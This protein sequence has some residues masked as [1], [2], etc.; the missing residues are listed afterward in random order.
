MTVVAPCK[1]TLCAKLIVRTT[2]LSFGFLHW[3]KT[4]DSNLLSLILVH[5]WCLSI[6]NARRFDPKLLFCCHLSETV[7]YLSCGKYKRPGGGG[8]G[9]GWTK[10]VKSALMAD[11]GVSAQIPLPAWPPS[12]LLL[13]VPWEPWPA[14]GISNPVQR[15][16]RSTSSW[17]I[18]DVI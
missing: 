10:L 8:G 6:S 4:W 16:Y 1:I 12:L 18:F 7:L 13:T 2:V 5:M 15:Y 11:E 14:R 17:L 9:G 3:S